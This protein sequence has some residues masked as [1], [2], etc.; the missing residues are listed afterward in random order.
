MRTEGSH[1]AHRLCGVDRW[2][3]IEGLIGYGKVET[4]E[5]IDRRRNNRTQVRGSSH[6]PR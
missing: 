2:C 3:T 1:P 4:H 5:G 6:A